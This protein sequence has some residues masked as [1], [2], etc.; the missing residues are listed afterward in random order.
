MPPSLQGR[1]TCV[2]L[3]A[4]TLLTS[5]EAATG[6]TKVTVKDDAELVTTLSPVFRRYRLHTYH[7]FSYKQRLCYFL[8]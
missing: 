2:V 7:Y 3:S 6:V 1:T 4:V 8:H 5:P